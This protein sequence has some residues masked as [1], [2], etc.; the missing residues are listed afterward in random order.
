MEPNGWVLDVVP[1][2]ENVILV[3]ICNCFSC[4]LPR[5][6]TNNPV[7]EC[8]LV[9][10]IGMHDTFCGYGIKVLHIKC[11]PSVFINKELARTNAPFHWK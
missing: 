6:A 2:F 11:V 9:G 3:Q 7:E 5:N 1:H 4:L 10:T 8:N